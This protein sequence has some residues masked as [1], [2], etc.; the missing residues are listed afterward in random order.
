MQIHKGLRQTWQTFA[1]FII[2]SLLGLVIGF[3][4]LLNPKHSQGQG[5]GSAQLLLYPNKL[6]LVSGETLTIPIKVSS[7]TNPVNAVQVNLS[8]P[9]SSFDFSSIDSAGSAF[10]IQAENSGG[11]GIVRIARGT[12][13]PVTVI[14]LVAIVNLSAKTSVPASSI[15]VTADSA[16]VRSTDNINILSGWEV[17]FPPTPTSTPIAPTPTPTPSP[18]IIQSGFQGEYFANKS[19]SGN[20]A[21]VRIDPFIN[22]NW[23][24]GSPDPLIPKDYFSVRWTKQEFLEGGTYKFTLRHDDGMRVYIDNTKVYDRWFNQSARTRTRLISIPQGLH[25]VKVEF[26]ENKGKAQAYVSWARQ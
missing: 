4:F 13:T 9:A 7:G 16:V 17:I 25:F 1:S 12:T 5:T 15:T 26:Y 18:V 2:F 19:L 20:P 22:F 23:G 6:T 8:Y 21:I 24:R 3:F 11:G 14:N 10:E